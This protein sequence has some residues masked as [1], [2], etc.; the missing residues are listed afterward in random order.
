MKKTTL[1]TLTEKSKN[2]VNLVLTTIEG[3]KSTNKAIDDERQKND[4]MIAAIQNTNS[5]LDELKG[6]NEKIINNFEKLLQ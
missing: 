4:A 1:Q 5:S 3:L 2:A 6:N